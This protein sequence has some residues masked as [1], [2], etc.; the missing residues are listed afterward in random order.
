MKQII[1]VYSRNKFII[2]AQYKTQGKIR[3]VLHQQIAGFWPPHAIQ[4]PLNEQNHNNI[5]IMNPRKFGIPTRLW[6]QFM[7]SRI[8]IFR[9]ANSITGCNPCCAPPLSPLTP[10]TPFR[11]LFNLKFS[12]C[13]LQ[14]KISQISMEANKP[15]QCIATSK[16]DC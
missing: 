15:T 2:I 14:D 16:F 4:W 10:Y 8:S 5:I 13:K 7:L 11:K 12:Y 1:I 6:P 3:Q 9:D